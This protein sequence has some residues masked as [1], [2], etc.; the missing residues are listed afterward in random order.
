MEDCLVCGCN[1]KKMDLYI[2]PGCL[3]CGK[4]GDILTRSTICYHVDNC[5]QLGDATLRIEVGNGDEN[6]PYNNVID[7]NGDKFPL[8]IIFSNVEFIV[9]LYIFFFYNFSLFYKT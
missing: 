3:I 8:N 6:I 9:L 5:F 1:L 7:E 4:C 2:A